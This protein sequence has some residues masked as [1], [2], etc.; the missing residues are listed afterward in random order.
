MGYSMHDTLVKEGTELRLE[1]K[2]HLE[3]NDCI[4][5]I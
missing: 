4:A 5:G 2:N 1:Y 3:A